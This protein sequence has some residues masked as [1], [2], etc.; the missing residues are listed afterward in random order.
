M[1]GLM[2]TAMRAANRTARTR[3]AAEMV[4]RAAAGD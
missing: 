4:K 2:E 1:R 3:T